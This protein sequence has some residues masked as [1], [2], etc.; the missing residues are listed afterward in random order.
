[1]VTHMKWN[2][3]FAR[4]KICILSLVVFLLGIGVYFYIS[5]WPERYTYL[6]YFY[7]R[8]YYYL[9]VEMKFKTALYRVHSYLVV[10]RPDYPVEPDF[11]KDKIP[12]LNRFLN[13]CRKLDFHHA[14]ERAL[15]EIPIR[16]SNFLSA[17]SMSLSYV[18][19]R[20]P[21]DYCLQLIF[22]LKSLD[23]DLRQEKYSG[24]KPQL[25]E[26]F[27]EKMLI[28][29]QRN[30]SEFRELGVPFTPPR[31]ILLAK[32]YESTRLMVMKGEYKQAYEI[33][34]PG[35][36]AKEQWKDW[37]VGYLWGWGPLTELERIEW[38]YYYFGLL[39]ENGYE[40]YIEEVNIA[41]TNRYQALIELMQRQISFMAT[42]SFIQSGDTMVLQKHKDWRN[43]IRLFHSLEN[44]VS[45]LETGPRKKGGFASLTFEGEDVTLPKPVDKSAIRYLKS[46]WQLR[47]VGGRYVEY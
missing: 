38:L 1:M 42:Y 3:R 11:P 16:Y 36:Y 13:L 18:K 10:K 21:K 29:V 17:V 44:L 9:A 46:I 26:T 5:V 12:A 27:F 14:Y 30:K 28:H 32:L 19:I 8:H 4:R 34:F 43:S 23:E 39:K 25:S 15:A 6:Y 22:V 20:M 40:D 35:E 24:Y 2:I 47:G 31:E 41:E 7:N 37:E 45:S 33:T